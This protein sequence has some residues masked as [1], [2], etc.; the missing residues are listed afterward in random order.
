MKLLLPLLLL[1]SMNAQAAEKAVY[2]GEGRYACDSDSTDCAVLKQR[3][4]EQARRRRE[5]YENEQRYER[6]ERHESSQ[7]E[8]ETDDY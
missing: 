1:L 3:N 6:E 4:E 8:Y 5:R 2:V 7:R